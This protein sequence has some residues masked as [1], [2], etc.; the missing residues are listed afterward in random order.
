MKKKFDPDTA[1]SYSQKQLDRDLDL[2]L[3]VRPEFGIPHE[4]RTQPVINIASDWSD[5]TS[6]EMLEVINNAVIELQKDQEQRVLDAIL[7]G[8]K[9]QGLEL[10]A[11]MTMEDL[12]EAIRRVNRLDSFVVNVPDP[13]FRDRAINYAVH[14]NEH[15]ILA[16]PTGV[17][18]HAP[19]A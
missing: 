1:Q 19:K 6:G 10:P 18:A 14:F 8:L 16:S 5:K 13:L 9:E 17:I 4:C 7:Q 2:C 11:D 15:S 3:T 12:R